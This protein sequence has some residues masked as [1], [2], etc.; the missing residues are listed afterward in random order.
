MILD[1]CFETVEAFK[2][3]GVLIYILKIVLPI[4]IIVMGIKDTLGV[5]LKGDSESVN[6]SLKTLFKRVIACIL[7]FLVPTIIPSII[8]MLVDDYEDNSIAICNSC[9]FNPFSDECD[10]YIKEFRASK[11]EVEIGEDIY[12][13]GSLDIETLDE[14]LDKTSMY[15]NNEEYGAEASGREQGPGPKA[16]AFL[17]AWQHISKQIEEDVK[18]GIDWRWGGGINATFKKA[19]RLGNYKTYCGG[20]NYWALKDAGIIPK[21]KFIYGCKNI[22]SKNMTE[23][24]VNE[25]FIVI[26]GDGRTARQMMDDGDMLPG[27][28]VYW[29]RVCHT[30]TYAGNYLWF[31]AGR[32]FTGGHGTPD[33]YHFNTLGPL[34]ITFYESEPVYKIL[35]IRE[36]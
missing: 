7:I 15:S 35:R 33:N 28:T 13:D 17:A 9:I 32:N 22:E 19:R 1:I 36:E 27:D 30:N 18:N 12:I 6:D 31:D 20:A 14:P 8:K 16:E 10:G 26:M 29:T 21:D 25:A 4:I 5:V 2:I 24:E 3:L 34:R 23:E 11:E